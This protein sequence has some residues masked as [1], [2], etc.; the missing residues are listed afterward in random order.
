MSKRQRSRYRTIDATLMSAFELVYVDC[1]SADMFISAPILITVHG[2]MFTSALEL[3]CSQVR[4]YHS[5]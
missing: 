2:N 3:E 1:I 4:R 5:Q